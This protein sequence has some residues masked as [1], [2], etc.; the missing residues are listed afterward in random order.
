MLTTCRYSAR[1]VAVLLGFAIGWY[2][3]LRT[4]L[5][6]EIT[7][8]MSTALTGPTA[9]LGHDMRAGVLA[10]FAEANHQAGI[11]HHQVRLMALDDSYEPSLCRPNMLRLIQQDNVV[12]VIGNV[13]T[14]TAVVAVPLANDLRTPLVAPFTGASLLR[15]TP[16]DRYVIN[17]RASYA[18]ETAAMVKGLVD[19]GIEPTEIAFF[20]QDDSYGDDGYYG[21]LAAIR[22]YRPD[23]TQAMIAHGRYERN[24]L[25]VESALA[26]LLVHSPQPKAVIMIGAYAPCAKFIRLAKENSFLPTF[27]NVSFVGVDPLLGSLGPHAEGVIVTQVVP[28]YETDCPLTVAYRRA[29][30]TYQSG[31][32]LSFGS[33]EGYIAGKLLLRAIAA[34]PGTVTRESIINAF[35]EMDE[36]DLGLG[37]PLH[38]SPADHQA[39]STVW[40]TI[41]RH[42]KVVPMN[43]ST[44]HDPQ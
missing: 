11:N 7:V 21:G 33:L 6:D 22:H 18:E 35:E 14:P 3:G 31:E 34:I 42:G 30:Q 15:K 40:P 36:F 28:H 1:L 16:P 2:S 39:S 24:T 10:A 25:S 32:P 4:T 44:W 8:G 13:G 20:T 26:D 38:L 5:A 12:A 29:M 37:V 43:W 9:A 27:L 17:F 23:V 41:I 19:A